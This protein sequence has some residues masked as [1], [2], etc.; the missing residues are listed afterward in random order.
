MF[1]RFSEGGRRVMVQAQEEARLMDHNFI[2]TEHLLLGVLHE[3]DGVA[4]DALHRTGVSL[5]AA[6]AKVEELRGPRPAAPGAGSPPFT[7]RAKKVLELSLREALS[8][9]HDY[10]GTEHVLLAIVREGDGVGARVLIA[11]GADLQTVRRAVLELLSAQPRPPRRR[12]GPEAAP[13]GTEP[14]A[15]IVVPDASGT[16]PDCPHCR[17]PL[18]ESARSR[19]LEP[20]DESGSPGPAFV[21]VYCAHCGRALT[22]TPTN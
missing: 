14:T 11:L 9:G 13:L 20:V 19:R 7:P 4:T 16:P 3:D 10:I 21:V 15:R 6:R 12:R 5:E 2:G 22:F 1:E 17:S 18:G 8:L